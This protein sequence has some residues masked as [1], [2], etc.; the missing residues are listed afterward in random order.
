[1]T[2]H[3][4]HYV[5]GLFFKDTITSQKGAPVHLNY[6]ISGRRLENI[7]Q[8]MSYKNFPIAYY[9][10]P[11]LQQRQMGGGRNINMAENFGPSWVSVMD[12][13]MQEWI[14]TY[15]FP[16]CVFD[17][18]NTHTFGNEYHTIVCDISKII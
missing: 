9:D 1:M 2:C 5:R 10:D 11:L 17:P 6:I 7:T 4:G 18:H 3:V 12:E 15:T 13:S 16:G 14:N 8:F